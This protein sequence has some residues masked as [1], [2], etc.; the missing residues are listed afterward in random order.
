MKQYIENFGKDVGMKLN[1]KITGKLKI[2]LAITFARE[3]GKFPEFH[4]AVFKANFEDG[5]NIGE[6]ALFIGS[7]LKE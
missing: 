1:G 2:S 7:L 3:K 5:K 4:E 6:I